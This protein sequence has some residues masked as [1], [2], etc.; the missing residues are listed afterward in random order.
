MRVV[1]VV[2]ICTFTSVSS[3]VPL[4]QKSMH[5]RSF[6]FAS[7]LRMGAN[8]DEEN[9]NLK[10]TE[11]V[12]SSFATEWKTKQDNA[13]EPQAKKR[14]AVVGGGWGG[15]GAAK[16]LCEAEGVEV[17]LL[18]ALSDPTGRTPFLSKTGK[19]G[20]DLCFIQR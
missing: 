7:Q 16:A 18:D 5:S 11:D 9:T 10:A 19:P 20:T 14:F 8:N 6:P 12:G 4:H 3:F 1:Q 2:F 17:T 13:I 15:W